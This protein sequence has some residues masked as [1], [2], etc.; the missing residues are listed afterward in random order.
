MRDRSR[1]SGLSAIRT[2]GGEGA[3]EGDSGHVAIGGEGE[4][5]SETDVGG[6]VHKERAPPRFAR[7]KQLCGEKL[8]EL[9]NAL[10]GERRL[11]PQR[12]RGAQRERVSATVVGAHGDD[13]RHLASDG[14]NMDG[15][16]R[17][18]ALDQVVLVEG[19]PALVAVLRR[20][21]KERMLQPHERC[22]AR[23]ERG[24][25]DAR[26]GIWTARPDTHG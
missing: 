5:F 12:R 1:V 25:A 15:D 19:G 7:L 18:E 16:A 24:A 10:E 17:V 9:A 11:R 23:S 13:T 4:A 26:L 8:R 6:H 14:I 2:Q 20:H 21:F 22:A 3:G